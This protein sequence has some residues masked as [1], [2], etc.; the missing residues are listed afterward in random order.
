MYPRF[1]AIFE[2]MDPEIVLFDIYELF[3]KCGLYFNLVIDNV[4]TRCYH[5]YQTN[6]MFKKEFRIALPCYRNSDFKSINYVN[7]ICII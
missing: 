6:K 3:D 7:N 5:G 4:L 2:F 1:I